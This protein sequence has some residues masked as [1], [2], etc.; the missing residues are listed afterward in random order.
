MQL[1]LLIPRTLPTILFLSITILQTVVNSTVIAILLN[2]FEKNSSVLSAINARD[3][4]SILPIYLALFIL[5]HLFQLIFSLDGLANKNMIMIFGLISFNTL[6]F[7]N[8]IIQITEI[9]A[10]SLVT[11]TDLHIIIWI[12]PAMILVTEGVYLATVW[13]IYKEF[14]WQIYKKIGADRSVKRMYL[15]YQVSIVD[16]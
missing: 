13:S 1:G 8:S 6:F 15:W 4:G 2:A 5:A 3:E 10:A 14:G 9:N 16:L 7:I 11:G 12:L